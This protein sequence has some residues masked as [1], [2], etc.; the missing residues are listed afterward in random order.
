MHF[1]TETYIVTL[2]RKGYSVYTE[3]YWDQ[4]GY[5]KEEFTEDLTTYKKHMIMPS[6]YV[7]PISNYNYYYYDEKN[8]HTTKECRF[9]G[10]L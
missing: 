2:S 7:P 10:K 9:I 8:K 5:N 4:L 1:N 3:Q 6:G